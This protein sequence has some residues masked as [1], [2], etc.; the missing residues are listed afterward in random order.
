M[1]GLLRSQRNLPYLHAVVAVVLMSWL[2][3]LFSA[4]CTMPVPVKAALD[5]MAACGEPSHHAGHEAPP[6]NPD[7]DCFYK[8][9][10]ESQSYP[11]VLASP[12]KWDL[13]ALVFCITWVLGCRFQSSRISRSPPVSDPPAGRRIPLIYRFC[14]L[15]N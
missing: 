4:T 2:A 6:A 10:L 13:P 7:R 14:T 12:I 8:P 1:R 9:C 3:L 5:T 11:G 15:L